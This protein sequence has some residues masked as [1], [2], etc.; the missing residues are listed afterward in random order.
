[1]T[2]IGIGAPW[3]AVEV[4]TLQEAGLKC[5]VTALRK[6]QSTWFE[7]DWA[8]RIHRETESI[9][10]IDRRFLWS[11]C[12]APLKFR[13]NYAAA[14]CNTLI[15]RRESFS[16][17][18]SALCH[19]FVACHWACGM[20]GKQVDLIHAQW[21]H[22]AGTVAM[23]AAWLMGVP[24]SFT[25]HAADLF[26]ERVALHDKIQRAKF[27]VCISDFHRQ[28]YLEHGALEQQLITVHCGI[29]VEQFGFQL[30]E[31]L[32]ETPHIITLGRLVE[33]KGNEYLIDACGLLRDRGVHVKCT[34]AGD[35]PLTE[36]LRQRVHAQ[37]LGDI[38]TVTGEP[39]VQ[40]ELAA[41]LQ[42][43]DIFAQPCVWSSDNDV[44][45]TPR[46]L[47]EAM[48]CGVPSISTRLAGIPDIIDDADSGLL[49]PPNDAESLAEAIERIVTEPGLAAHLSRGG[50]R[51]IERDF[52]L[53]DCLIPLEKKF[54]SL[55]KSSAGNTGISD[56]SIDGAI[57][58]ASTK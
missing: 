32:S 31:R 14:M 38:V 27:I 46:T 9:Y 15:G 51:K 6:P 20:R 56:S 21:I 23:Y 26:R 44:D 3:V 35:G 42:T 13:R 25:G 34:I 54:R 12:I 8:R 45:G 41:F 30:R 58:A 1:M 11:M 4:H 7:S 39:I 16:K 22:S 49:V 18:L 47:M 28:F 43:G 57:C 17:R 37:N 33:K 24:F 19:F 40:E 2:P 36:S 48:A 55:L 50:R 29:D 53:P 10:P 52:S 5:C